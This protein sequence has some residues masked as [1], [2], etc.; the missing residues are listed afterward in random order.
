MAV[1]AIGS[2]GAT[3][4]PSTNA[5]AQLSPITAWATTATAAMVINTS[6]TA[7]RPIGRAF[8]RRSRSEVKNAEE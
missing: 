1:A 2:V 7:S 5:V 6:P 3:T 8:A 4:A